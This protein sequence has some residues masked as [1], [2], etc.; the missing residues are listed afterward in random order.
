MAGTLSLIAGYAGIASAHD[1]FLQPIG[2]TL[3]ATDYFQV[4]C[5]DDGNGPAGRI[6]VSV[7]DDT[8]GTSILSLQVQKGLLA[9]NTTDAT[10]ADAVYSPVVSVAGGNGVYNILVDKTTAAA[11]V[12][13]ISYHCMTGAT[14]GVHTGTVISQKQNQ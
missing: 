14:G 3:S 11:R 7:K 12:Y 10:G 13:D 6:D 8:A 9:K 5:S 1:V 4:T 2:A